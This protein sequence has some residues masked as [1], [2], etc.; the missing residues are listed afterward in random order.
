MLA[1]TALV[2]CS[3]DDII[4]NDN[5]K[6]E[7]QFAEAYVTISIEAT[8]SSSRADSEGST[9]GDGHGNADHSGHINT[10]TTAENIIND[11]L[12]VM[13]SNGDGVVSLLRGTDFTGDDNLKSCTK[14]WQVSNVGD[15]NTLVVINPVSELLKEI[16]ILTNTSDNR[17]YKDYQ[18]EEGATGLSHS[19]VY[20][21]VLNFNYNV[22][23]TD[24]NVAMKAYYN[25][26]F[27]MTN[28]E[29]C[30]IKVETK[31]NNSENAA[32]GIA[33][34]ERAISKI[35]FRSKAAVDNVSAKNAYEVKIKSQT[36]EDVE[37]DGWFVSSKIQDGDKT[38][39]VW[40]YT[41]FTATD[42]NTYFVRLKADKVGVNLG[43]VLKEDYSTYFEQNV[44]GGY[45]YQADGTHEGYKPNETTLTGGVYYKALAHNA[46]PER[47]V[48][49]QGDI[50]DE[51]EEIYYVQLKKYALFNLSKEMYGV[52]HLAD[53]SYNTSIM[54]RLGEEN[55]V[56]LV[57]PKTTQKN[58]VT[59]D[60]ETGAWTL[61]TGVNGA[62]DWFYNVFAIVADEANKIG[63]TN[64]PNPLVYF[65]DLDGLKNDEEQDVSQKVDDLVS[66]TT[67]EHE[68]TGNPD[69]GEFMSYC[70]ENSVEQYNQH[71]GLSTGIIFVGQIYTDALCTNAV[72]VMY[73][74]NRKYYRELSALIEANDALTYTDA[75][76]TSVK[77][78]DNSTDEEAAK[79]EGLEVYKGGRCFYYSNKIKHFDDGEND[80]TTVKNDDGSETT[81]FTPGIMEFAIMRNNIYSLSIGTISEIGS[82]TVLP[83]PG[84]VV[85][86]QGAYITMQAKILPWIVRF[87]NINF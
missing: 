72:D 18:T 59:F 67:A 77:L 56:Y 42:N 7:V 3:D 52:R 36:Y 5:E 15:Y 83:T 69:I 4:Q 62:G 39:D 65:A 76:G 28:R 1:C 19:E 10:G 50:A 48:L 25:N 66:G 57:D 6:Q 17:T 13:S 68:T 23:A 43:Q 12:V 64:E 29:E 53:N 49:D 86:D 87:N 84:T 22:V 31:H 70:F 58:S 46:S 82:A 32:T 73:K 54:G 33:E 61:P 85:A 34:V 20:T 81:S 16:G 79:V 71:I 11:V 27:M 44:E 37:V 9:N 55:M 80:I 51:K 21:K 74:Y 45:V 63:T 78:K 41:T 35:T 26:G 60:S 40:S 14:T 47:V 30:V 24:N 38:I 2:G 75:N 8:S